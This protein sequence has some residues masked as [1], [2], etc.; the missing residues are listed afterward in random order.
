M[1]RKI[2][3]SLLKSEKN[4][5]KNNLN[6]FKI[7]FSLPSDFKFISLTLD[8]IPLIASTINQTNNSN[9][10]NYL[11]HVIE[12]NPTTALFHNSSLIAWCALADT[13]EMSNMVVHEDY[14]RQSFGVNLFSRHI[15]KIIEMG[16]IPF[17]LV[18]FWNDKSYNMCIKLE[19]EWIGNFS[20]FGV[21]KMTWNGK[22]HQN[23]YQ[24]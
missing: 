24:A 9:Y 18:D 13:G 11:K 3:E 14:Q 21:K 15:I 1:I 12:F 19:G 20:C 17:G 4:N 6:Y 10:I 7:F 2:I 23:W 16:R 8:D 5:F 22:P